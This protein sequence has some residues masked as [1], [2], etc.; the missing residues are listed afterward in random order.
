MM[1]CSVLKAYLE[2][3]QLTVTTTIYLVSSLALSANSQSLRLECIFKTQFTCFS[4]KKYLVD[5]QKNH[6]IEKV[7]LSI[8]NK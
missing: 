2:L 8:Q 1:F 4:T 3:W 7:L 5:T 6:L